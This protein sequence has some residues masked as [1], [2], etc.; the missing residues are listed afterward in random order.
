MAIYRLL[1]CHAFGSELVSL[2]T[3]AYE[4]VLDT[5]PPADQTEQINE[6]I[7]RRVVELALTGVRDARLIRDQILR[8]L[9][10]DAGDGP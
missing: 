9:D 8:S 5:L 7:A 2:M 10:R 1:Q 4:D 3:A 6:T